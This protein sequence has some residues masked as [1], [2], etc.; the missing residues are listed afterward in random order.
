MEK[1]DLSCFSGNYVDRILN[2]D[3]IFGKPFSPTK[4]MTAMNK[5]KV[6]ID[7]KSKR[8]R[9]NVSVMSNGALNSDVVFDLTNYSIG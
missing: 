2:K 8:G 3:N 7:T 9:R 6:S 5:I 1:G 4:P